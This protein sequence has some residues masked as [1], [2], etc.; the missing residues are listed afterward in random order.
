MLKVPHFYIATLH[1]LLWIAFSSHTQLFAQAGVTAVQ[2]PKTPTVCRCNGWMVAETDSFWVCCYGEQLPAAKIAQECEGLRRQLSEKWLSD[3]SPVPWAVKCMVVLHPSPEGYL[4]AV[5][6]DAG[7]T[8]GSSVVE[9]LKDCIAKRRID[10][11]GDRPDY[12][13]AALPHEL[14]HI[15]LADHFAGQS[16]PGLGR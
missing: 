3:K 1:A 8:T 5:G 9:R 12:L 16:L 4:A 13:T 6:Q 15:V 2:T 7:G 10:L 11:R 14:T